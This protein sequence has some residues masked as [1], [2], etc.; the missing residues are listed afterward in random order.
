MAVLI[1]CLV[2][3][4]PIVCRADLPDL[5]ALSD[6]D[7]LLVLDD[8]NAQLIHSNIHKTAVLPKGAYTAGEDL[9]IGSYIFTCLAKGKEWG[10]VTVCSDKGMGGRAGSQGER[11]SGDPADH[12]A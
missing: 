11:R 10:N 3:L 12:P 4:C 8:L 9:P 1:L 2:L 7:L 6:Q 5:N